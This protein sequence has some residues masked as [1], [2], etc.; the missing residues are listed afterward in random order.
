MGLYQTLLHDLGACGLGKPEY[1]K[2]RNCTNSGGT[3]L[4]EIPSGHNRLSGTMG[5]IFELHE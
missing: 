3:R 2:Q 4:D 5:D 1:R